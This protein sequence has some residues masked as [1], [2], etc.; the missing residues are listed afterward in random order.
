MDV[1][2]VVVGQV[3]DAFGGL[4]QQVKE[5]YAA[6]PGNPAVA[7]MYCKATAGVPAVMFDVEEEDVVLE[8]ISLGKKLMQQF[9]DEKYFAQYTGKTFFEVQQFAEAMP[10]LEKAIA[11]EHPHPMAIARWCYAKYKLEGSFPENWPDSEYY[12]PYDWYLSAAVSSEWETATPVA[13]EQHLV[14][15]K[16]L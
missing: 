2:P 7:V 5:A 9:P 12:F 14:L 8:Q 16:F 15:N 11:T 10:Y 13:R 1:L 3:D 6:H 4:L